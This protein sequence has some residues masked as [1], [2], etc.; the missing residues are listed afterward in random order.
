MHSIHAEIVPTIDPVAFM[1]FFEYMNIKIRPTLLS[2]SFPAIFTMDPN[3]II[4][5]HNILGI[6]SHVPILK[7]TDCFMN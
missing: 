1:I 2:L 7:V 6:I 5:H 4:F 3:L